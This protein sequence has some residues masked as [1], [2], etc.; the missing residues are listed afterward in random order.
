[1]N[2]K[3]ISALSDIENLVITENELMSKH[4]SFKIGGPAKLFIEAF[5]IESSIK[6]L[7]ALFDIGVSPLVLGN[8]SNMLFPDGTYENPVIKLSCSNISINENTITAESGALLPSVSAFAMK[9]SLT[10]LEFAQGIPGTI[11]GAL[12]MNAGAYGGEIANVVT[13]STYFANGEVKTLSAKEHNFS[14]RDSFYKKHPEC[15]LLSAEFSL[16]RGDKDTISE[17]MRELG[18]KR[19]EKQPLELPNAGS[20]FKRPVGYFAGALIEQCG[21]KG[22]SIGGASV[23]PKHAGF[24]VNTGGATSEDVKQLINHIQ[25]TVLKE[26]GVYLECEIC[27]L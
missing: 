20:V 7:S 19:R 23:S 27:I 5:S 24:I 15:I 17:T 3:I 21:L 9:N 8:G 11:G 2:N 25:E 4:T 12:V 1:M 22:F 14:Y 18:I 6:A 16:S 26:T 13:S 10:G